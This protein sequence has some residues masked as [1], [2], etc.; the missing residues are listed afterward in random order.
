MKKNI[1]IA[2]CTLKNNKNTMDNSMPTNLITSVELDNSSKTHLPKFTQGKIDCLNSPISSKEIESII[3]NLPRE[4]AS[5]P[6]GSLVNSTK[7][8]REKLY[9]FSIISSQGRSKR[10][11]FISFYEA[12]ITLKAKPDKSITGKVYQYL[13]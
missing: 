3:K 12:S 9:P 1:T 10:S 11:T 5:G 13:S 4:K 8:L 6:M 2:P 7:N